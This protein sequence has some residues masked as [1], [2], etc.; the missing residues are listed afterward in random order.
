MNICGADFMSTSPKVRAVGAAVSLL[1]IEP[2][3]V[4]RMRSAA[5]QTPPL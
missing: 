4:P 5:P 3:I 1:D 2:K